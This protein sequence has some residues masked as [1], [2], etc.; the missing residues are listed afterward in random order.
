MQFRTMSESQVDEHATCAAEYFWLTVRTDLS[1]DEMSKEDLEALLYS[2]EEAA[3]A[4]GLFDLDSDLKVKESEVHT[5][6]QTLYRCC[7]KTLAPQT[8]ALFVALHLAR[9]Q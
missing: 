9:F 4:F 1:S 2:K 6:M 8:Y 3:Y 5:R 7:A